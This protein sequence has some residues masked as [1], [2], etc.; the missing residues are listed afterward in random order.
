MF[1][2]LFDPQR[3]SIENNRMASLLS[4][5]R[6]YQGLDATQMCFRHVFHIY[7]GPREFSGGWPL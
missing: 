1:I 7:H 3:S 4:R 2:D 5:V 6:N